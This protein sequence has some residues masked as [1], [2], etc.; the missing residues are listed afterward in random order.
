[1]NVEAEE[2]RMARLKAQEGE[3]AIMAQREAEAFAEHGS[4][5]FW[6]FW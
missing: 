1:M 5:P 3:S 6:K 4:K 2:K